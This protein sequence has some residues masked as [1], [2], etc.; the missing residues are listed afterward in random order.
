LLQGVY[1]RAGVGLGTPGWVAPEETMGEL[2]TEKAD[3]F[4]FA[5]IMWEVSN[6]IMAPAG[7]ACVACMDYLL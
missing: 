5:M 2:V 1:K 3:V 4:S 7:L 6:P